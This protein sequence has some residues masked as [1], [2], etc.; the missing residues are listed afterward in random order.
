M[1]NRFTASHGIREIYVDPF[2]MAWS[3]FDSCLFDR[4][5]ELP[6]FQLVLDLASLLYK[7]NRELMRENIWNKM[8]ILDL[9]NIIKEIVF[10]FEKIVDLSD[11]LFCTGDLRTKQDCIVA[12][13]QF[14]NNEPFDFFDSL[15][16]IREIMDFI[17]IELKNFKKLLN[18][19]LSICPYFFKNSRNVNVSEEI[20]KDFL[21]QLKN[22]YVV[23]K[24]FINKK[25]F[26]IKNFL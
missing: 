9:N 12:F 24:F 17:D 13:D 2:E 11:D 20:M 14:M 3:K 22:Q 26:I 1:N 4:K 6:L 16:E 19:L 8:L 21:F 25:F 15:G 10:S 23:K 7:Y 5:K 18:D